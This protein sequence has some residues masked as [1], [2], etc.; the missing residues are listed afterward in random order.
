MNVPFIVSQ[1]RNENMD[2]GRIGAKLSCHPCT[3]V[4]ESWAFEGHVIY[5]RTLIKH[6]FSLIQL[7]FKAEGHDKESFISFFKP[8]H[9][10]LSIA[11]KKKLIKEKIDKDYWRWGEIALALF[12]KLIQMCTFHIFTSNFG[13]I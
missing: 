5:F 12:D 3:E 10:M 13:E 7:L 11:C 1:K 9:L 4:R 8:F 2:H 6:S